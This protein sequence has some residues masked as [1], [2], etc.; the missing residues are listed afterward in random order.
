MKS[1]TWTLGSICFLFAVILAAALTMYAAPIR[2]DC[3]K[4]GSINSTLASLARAGN[5]RTIFVT[6]TCKENIGIGAFDHL[7]LQASP[8]ATIQDQSNGSQPVV[9]IFNSYDVTLIGFTI[10]GGSS[11]VDCEPDSFCELYLNRIQQSY[12]GVRFAS[13][14]GFVSSNSI[15]NSGYRG[16]AVLNGASVS[17]TSN[18]ISG[19][20]L[21]G[22][23]VGY[24]STLTAVSDIV[25]NSELLRSRSLL[26]CGPKA[27]GCG[28]Q[29]IPAYKQ[30][31]GQYR[32]FRL[33][34]RLLLEITCA[35]YGPPPDCKR[36]RG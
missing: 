7:T 22:M 9:V 19:S 27:M 30:T 15:S 3:G 13:S 17:T 18:T 33:A 4:G 34:D 6:G 10:T 25:E 29:S 35:M 2:A 5:T 28:T 14:H 24:G 16:I 23:V 26:C 1:R 8:I 36:T 20:G 12:D 31:S 32:E 11:G 21:A